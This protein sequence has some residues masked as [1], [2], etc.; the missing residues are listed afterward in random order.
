MAKQTSVIQFTGRLGNIVGYRRKSAHF[1]RGTP[2]TIRQSVA[3]KR[4]AQRFGMASKKAAFIRHAIYT[5][6]DVHCDSTH[7]N[8]LTKTLIPSAG[9]Q[10]NAIKGFRF[11]QCAGTDHFFPV[12]PFFAAD[13]ALHIPAQT[14]RQYKGITALEI[15]MIATRIDCTTRR[16]MGTQT[17]TCSID[18]TVP[19]E[20]T[21]FPVDVAGIG[22]LIITLQ[23][24]AFNG[25]ILSANKQH[26]VADIIA[27]Q[28]PQIPAVIHRYFSTQTITAHH[29]AQLPFITSH[30]QSV[31][32]IIQRE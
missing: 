29:A 17:S 20:G 16:V 14:L 15:K 3:T 5:A 12:S 10:I 24:R 2:D 4:A 1:L 22:T 19:F 27:I 31:R 8:R 21:I 18:A 32:T 7:V 30:H 9:H 26:L 28:A 13:H 25:A 6:L 11:N 23:I